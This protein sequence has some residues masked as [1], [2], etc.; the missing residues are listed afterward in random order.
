MINYNSLFLACIVVLLED[1]GDISMM[2]VG[3]RLYV[4]ITRINENTNDLILSEKEAW[5]CIS[6]FNVYLLLCSNNFLP[7]TVPLRFQ[8]CRR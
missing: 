5:V 2:Q 4:Q 6:R 3:R 1:K 7:D 8:L